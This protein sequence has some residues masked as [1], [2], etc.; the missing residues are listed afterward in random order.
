[1]SEFEAGSISSRNRL[2]I[3]FV[4]CEHNNEDVEE[5]HRR[6]YEF[7]QIIMCPHVLAVDTSGIADQASD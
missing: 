1:M 5:K 3:A 4:T 7:R 2:C 6:T